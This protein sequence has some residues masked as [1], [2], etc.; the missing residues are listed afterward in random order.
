MEFLA[1]KLTNTLTEVKRVKFSNPSDKKNVI[2]AINF[3]LDIVNDELKLK[4]QVIQ[5]EQLVPD[6]IEMR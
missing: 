5:T 6:E 4:S 1:I 2:N 3:A